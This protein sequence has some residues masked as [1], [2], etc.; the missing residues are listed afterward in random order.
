MYGLPLTRN[1][2]TKW[3]EGGGQTACLAPLAGLHV[4]AC[5]VPQAARAVAA[6]E[7]VQVAPIV[8]RAQ[9]G[10]APRTWRRIAA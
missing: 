9:A 4:E 5:E 3:R 7:Q 6:A 8:G 1:R 2:Q 10:A